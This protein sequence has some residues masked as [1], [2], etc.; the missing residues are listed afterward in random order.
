MLLDVGKF[1][2]KALTD[3]VS[4]NYLLS[5]SQKVLCVLSWWKGMRKVYGIAFIRALI[6]FMWV[7]F[8]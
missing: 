3:L 1:K 2:V 6:I 4:G 8:S 7:S 5:G